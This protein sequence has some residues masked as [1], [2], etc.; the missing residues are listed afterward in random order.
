[1]GNII[2]P[3]NGPIGDFALSGNMILGEDTSISQNNTLTNNTYSG[4]TING[5]AGVSLG[6]GNLIYLDPSLSRWKLID[7]NSNTS[8]AGDATGI[9][10]F[11]VSNNK[12]IGDSIVIL[13][14]GVIRADSIFPSL[15][16][17]NPLY[18]S[19][20]PG[21]ITATQPSTANVIIRIIGFSLGTNLV[22]FNPSNDYVT[23]I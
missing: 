3:Q 16:V 9:I 10:G 21:Y 12:S 18:I 15:I 14:N 8:E 11:C 5:V 7:A 23:H 17:N 22:Y 6:F 20:S 13:L 2:K 1:M 4:L 19:E